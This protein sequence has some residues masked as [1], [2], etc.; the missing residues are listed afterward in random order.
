MAVRCR[1]CAGIACVGVV[2]LAGGAPGAPTALVI[3]V[4][5][6]E[7]S[8]AK[9][10]AQLGAQE[11]AHAARLFGAELD[12]RWIEPAQ[13]R[14]DVATAAT[15]VVISSAAAIG[16]AELVRLARE[17]QLPVLNVEPR[18]LAL[19]ACD[20][21]LFHIAPSEQMLHAARAQAQQKVT[22]DD[23]V[24]YWHPSLERY[25]AAQLNE[26]YR[27]AHGRDMNEAAWA[28]WFAVK[29][30]WEAAQRTGSSEPRDLAT[31]LIGERAIFDGHKGMPL[32]FRAQTQQLRQPV[33]II[34][35]GA[36]L[37]EVPSP[38]AAVDSAA[39]DVL[40]RAAGA[41]LPCAF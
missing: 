26:R 15:P 6:P 24:A 4:A 18:G 37:E 2:A 12:V 8:D 27:R 31:F 29:L 41:E 10:G 19:R 39:V 20:P 38:R 30:A 33:Y 3:A 35:N 13:W 11:A 36:L 25:G 1:L 22:D 5:L 32:S 34:R 40:E 14:A 21:L 23:S 7:A 16:A 28:G 9:R 17:Q